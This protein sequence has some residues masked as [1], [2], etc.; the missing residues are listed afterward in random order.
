MSPGACPQ[1]GSSPGSDSGRG[2]RTH[3]TP[4]SA[5]TKAH[6]EAEARLTMRQHRGKLTRGGGRPAPNAGSETPAGSGARAKNHLLVFQV[7]LTFFL[8]LTTQSAQNVGVEKRELK[9]R[10]TR[11]LEDDAL[12]PLSS[13]Q[14][15]NL[16]SQR[17]SGRC[18]PFVSPQA[19]FSPSGCVTFGE[20]DSG[21]T[22]T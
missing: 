21:F 15:V 22:K 16:T 10:N 18:S 19:L 2:D 8:L 7:A 20:I 9:L 1:Q 11:V 3:R 6:E 4:G 5:G 14:H 17:R 12:I 13:R